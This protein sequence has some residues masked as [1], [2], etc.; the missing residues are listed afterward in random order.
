MAALTCPAEMIITCSPESEWG[1]LIGDA[2]H[3][4]PLHILFPFADAATLPDME[5][6]HSLTGFAAHEVGLRRR[7]LVHC[8]AG[9][10]R[11]ALITGLILY[12]LG[13]ARQAAL[14]AYIRERNPRALTIPNEGGPF[15]AKYLEELP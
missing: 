13:V 10:N 14:V 12:H 15:F 7:V 4:R 8:T 5:L 1:A 3:D 2:L 9:R 11:S 6:A